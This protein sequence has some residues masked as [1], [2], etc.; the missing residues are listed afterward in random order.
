MGSFVG[1]I[2]S[3]ASMRHDHRGKRMKLLEKYGTPWTFDAATE[4]NFRDMFGCASLHVQSIVSSA[5]V[6]AE[7]AHAGYNAHGDQ[8]MQHPDVDEAQAEAH[9]KEVMNRISTLRMW[10]IE[11][12]SWIR[13]MLAIDGG[14]HMVAHVLAGESRTG[15]T[16]SSEPYKERVV[17]ILMRQGFAHKL[18]MYTSAI[19][20]NKLR[21]EYAATS[22]G[23]GVQGYCLAVATKRNE[24][25]TTP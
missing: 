23:P 1:F 20:A 4:A 3:M 7:F 12:M 19:N 16:S 10:S 9:A 18:V 11:A 15:T 13:S 21:H 5:E 6:F 14:P 22:V 24:T 8:V 17:E 2:D 25:P